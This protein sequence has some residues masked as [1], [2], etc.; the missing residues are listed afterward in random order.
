MSVNTNIPP[1]ESAS[2][3]L[4]MA[5]LIKKN[6]LLQG[7]IEDPEDTSKKVTSGE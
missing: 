1:H 5:T 4:F 2:A 7:G 3:E 6:I